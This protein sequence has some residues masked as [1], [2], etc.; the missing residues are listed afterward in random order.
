V[1]ISQNFVAFSEYMN[2]N[3]K[4]KQLKFFALKFTFLGQNRLQTSIELWVALI[5]IA[6]ALYTMTLAVAASGGL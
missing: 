3:V 6:I 5:A 4:V 1:K 2:F